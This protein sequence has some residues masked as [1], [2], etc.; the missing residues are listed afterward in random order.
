[1]SDKMTQI[2]PAG[3]LKWILAE[4]EAHGTVFG[5]KQLFY[6]KEG[7]TLPMFSGAL[8]TPFGP[9]AGPHTQL[10]QNIIAAYAGGA[11]FFELKTVQTLDGEDLPVSKPCI[12]AED[13]CYNV[14]WSTELYVPQALEEYVKAWFFLKL[15]A[16]EYG[17]GDPNGFVFNMSVGYDYDGIRSKKIDDFI[18]GLRDASG[19]AV[20]QECKDAAKACLSKL[21]NV[22]EAYIDA[23]SPRVCESITL[24]TLHGCPPQEIERIASYL[25]N[26]KGLNTYIK[27]NPTLLGYQYARETLDALGFD[28]IAFDDHHFKEDLQ[29][30]DAIPMLRRLMAQ[31]EAKGVCFGV[32]LTNTFPVDIAAGE[33]PGEEMYMS[34]R[35][36][37]PLTISVAENLAREFEGKLRISFSGGADAFNMTDIVKAGIWPVTIATT[38]LKV[39]GYNRVKQI[40]DELYALPY[41]DWAG[42]DANAVGALRKAAVSGDAYRKSIKPLPP[43]KTDERVPLTDC[44]FAPCE[45]GCPIHQDIPAYVALAGDGQYLEALRL[46]TEKNPLPFITGTICNHRCMDKCT[47][48]FYE[49][50]VKIRD[51]KLL[52]A[53]KAMDALLDE[54]Q[55]PEKTGGKVA[56]VGG[57]AAGMAAAVFLAREGMDVT[58]YEEKDALGGI[59]RH[60]VPAFRV[61][62][63]VVE[64]DE[65]LLRKVG[66]R[67]LTGTKA[68]SVEEL[69]KQGFEHIVLAIGA[70]KPGQLRLE[71]GQAVNVLDFLS[72]FRAGE[73]QNLGKNVVIVGGGNT[74][75]D[76]ARAAKRAQGVENVYIVYRRTKR[77]MPADEEE[78]RYAIEDGVEFMELLSPKAHEN[79]TL[80]C[81]AMKLGAPDESGRRSPV[82]TEES[83][84]VPADTVIA[85]VGEKVNDAA[86]KALGVDIAENGR[87]A[88]DAT[89]MT[90]VD[91][92]YIAGDAQR[93][94]ATVVEAIADAR[95]VAN[96]ITGKYALSDVCVMDGSERT[97][98][99]VLLYAK[100]AQS[101]AQ[102]CLRCNVVCENCVDV[103]PNRANISIDMKEAMP[104]IVHV[105][106]L[107]NEC[108]N[109]ETFCP[110]ASAPYKDKFTLFA[111]EQDF[112][113]SENEGFLILRDEWYRVRLDGE[114]FET[115]GTDVDAML[116]ELMRT[117]TKGYAYLI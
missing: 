71:K 56:V 105:D 44:F 21:K 54:T 23:I 96:A 95:D 28:Y 9:A 61:P 100:D 99:G 1:M 41:K 34:G 47:R 26:E 55:P 72:K 4:M 20:W 10:A 48:D 112:A 115:D 116:G 39:G 43:R 103:C 101:E 107:C 33:L 74:A 63:E 89:L 82:P 57:G 77:Y 60:V 94:P 17:F 102:R 93:G 30:K 117:V 31:S 50:S 62:A 58:L 66:V 73:T 49:E 68:P 76:A 114:E 8:E 12:R 13:E 52:C 24:S 7:K 67:I 15:L 27:C 91:N 51:T 80:I 14:E 2:G 97:K 90:S 70:Y 32:K 35:S 92:V 42:V 25:I 108:G 6:A 65:K 98:K 110:Y 84:L 83:V 75:M 106:K 69:K 109:C 81:Q 104:Q 40:A 53:N 64:N 22:D 16:R 86:L 18:E 87:A 19:L 113:D 46:I 38:L 79:G 59:V 3:L 111:S 88:V 29:Y 45:A 36:L 78:L 11:R 37:Y 5:V 85:A